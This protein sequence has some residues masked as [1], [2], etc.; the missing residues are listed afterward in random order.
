MKALLN[1]RAIKI[2]IVLDSSEV[3]ALAPPDGQPRA[4]LRVNVGGRVVSADIAAKSLRKA[5]ALIR[6][7]GADGCV[8][9]LQ[10][11][12]DQTDAIIEAGII[13]QVKQAKAAA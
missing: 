11:K 5:I 2:S 8:A 9:L 4:T 3:A 10:G 12:L 7:T 1:G 13:A 6:E